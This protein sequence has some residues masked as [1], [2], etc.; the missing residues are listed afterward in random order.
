MAPQ[1][2]PSGSLP[3]MMTTRAILLAG[4]LLV[5]FLALAPTAEANT[6]EPLV[7]CIVWPVQIHPCTEVDTPELCLVNPRICVDPF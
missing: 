1:L 2:I 4:L 3:P 6:N 7:I 5:G